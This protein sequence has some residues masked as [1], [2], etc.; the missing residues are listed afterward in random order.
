MHSESLHV[1]L[2]EDDE[3][4]YYLTRDVIDSIENAS[5][6]IVWCDTFDKGLQALKEQDF[7]IA[8]IDFRIGGRTGIDF[9]TTAKA[10]GIEVP[11]VLLTGLQDYEIDIAA[12]KAGAVDYL[13]KDDLDAAMVERT[14]RFA[15]ANAAALRSLAARSSLLQT[16]LD[17]TGTG[18]AAV[19]ANGELIAYNKQFVD[20]VRQLKLKSGPA[21]NLLTAGE[22]DEKALEAVVA[23][24]LRTSSSYT[25]GHDDLCTADDRILNL[26]INKTDEGGSVVVI[27]DIT[28]QRLLEWNLTHA[29]EEA[30]AASRLKTTFL[31]TIG[32]ELRTPLNAI[33]G[34][35]E[36]IQ[37]GARS[38]TDTENIEEFI[39]Y[40]LVSGRHLLGMINEILEFVK[41]EAEENKLTMEDLCL[42]SELEYCLRLMAPHAK[43]S[44]IKLEADLESFSGSVFADSHALRRMVTNL[45]SNAIKFTPENGVVTLSADHNA[46]GSLTITVTDTGIGIEEECLPLVVQP[47]YQV[48]NDS[49]R[50][51]E[52]TG[53]G[54]SIVNSLAK[55]HGATLEVRSAE[56][57]GTKIT[58]EFPPRPGSAQQS[59]DLIQKVS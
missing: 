24:I 4:D 57:S 39:D 41:S 47:F 14:I 53:L 20:L 26:S 11:M 42:R 22:P 59:E 10:D 40:V 28:Q 2:L 16:T 3:D 1:L 50:Q 25:I 31:A 13:N 7:D 12:S 37:A 18:L 30:E 8:L 23:E 15:C 19:E 56:G 27:Q 6:E 44:Q 21:S 51:Y 36:L 35:S 33:I 58:I 52:G 29:K 32:H 38:K 17:N 48:Q 45:L 55:L 46:D 49:D 54:L 34:F 43:S 5:Y 9:L